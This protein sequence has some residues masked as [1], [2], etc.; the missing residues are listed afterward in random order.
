[1]TVPGGS[2]VEHLQMVRHSS[3]LMLCHRWLKVVF[4]S[5]RNLPDDPDNND[6]C[7]E[8][9]RACSVLVTEGLGLLDYMMKMGVEQLQFAP[10]RWTVCPLSVILRGLDSTRFYRLGPSSVQ[11]C[12][13]LP[14]QG[15]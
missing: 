10:G 14:R 5:F 3:K 1:M 15:K 9:E 12:D 8:R 2:G 11:L 4:E 6:A 13:V 7:A